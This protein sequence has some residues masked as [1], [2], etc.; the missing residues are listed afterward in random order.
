MKACDFGDNPTGVWALVASIR[1]GGTDITTT[2]MAIYG[3][4][5]VLKNLTVV[6]DGDSSD[7][8]IWVTTGVSE[9]TVYLPEMRLVRHATKTGF[10][11][12]RHLP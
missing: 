1:D 3:G 11:E 12:I 5:V 7:E 4:G 2:A 8:P 9:S 10:Y 6:C